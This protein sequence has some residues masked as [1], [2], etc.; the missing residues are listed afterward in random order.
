M[1]DSANIKS[2]RI[3]FNI[4]G[5]TDD[6]NFPLSIPSAD[7]IL[8]NFN[9]MYFIM[10]GLFVIGANFEFYNMFMMKDNRVLDS[11]KENRVNPH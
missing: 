7:N 2:F 1:L 4:H 10:I 11:N 3:S 9:F 6:H 5:Y 8:T